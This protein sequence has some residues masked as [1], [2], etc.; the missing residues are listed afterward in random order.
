VALIEM[1]P[2]ATATTDPVPRD[3][4]CVRG[5]LSQ[6]KE[7]FAQTPVAFETGEGVVRRLRDDLTH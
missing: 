1:P 7:W 2:Y 6:V 3:T 4:A 5:R